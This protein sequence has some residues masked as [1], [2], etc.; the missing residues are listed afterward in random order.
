MPFPN[1]LAQNQSYPKHFISVFEHNCFPSRFMAGFTTKMCVFAVLKKKKDQVLTYC[2]A[3]LTMK[4]KRHNQIQKF[5]YKELSGADISSEWW[6]LSGIMC[7][8]SITRFLCSDTYC[9]IRLRTTLS[10]ISER[11]SD[12]IATLCL[13]NFNFSFHSI[14]NSLIYLRWVCM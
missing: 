6:M 13:Q 8:L 9:S 1:R 5:N 4:Y 14:Y 7:L 12:Y 10:V 11:L 2:F 3:Q